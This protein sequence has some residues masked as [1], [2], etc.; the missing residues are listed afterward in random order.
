M[1]D[2]GPAKLVCKIVKIP[3]ENEKILKSFRLEPF[4]YTKN[5]TFIFTI[6]VLVIVVHCAQCTGMIIVYLVLTAGLQVQL[7]SK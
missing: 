4:L 5:K 2:P 7:W 6:C 3:V 1:F